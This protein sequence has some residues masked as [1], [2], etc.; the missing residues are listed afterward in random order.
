[1]HAP[2]APDGTTLASG[3]FDKSVCVAT[4][5]ALAITEL[6]LAQLRAYGLEVL[7]ALR[8]HAE[9]PEDV[10]AL[11]DYLKANAPLQP[12]SLDHIRVSSAG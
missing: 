4:S 7:E 8:T 1:M 6:G 9:G 11:E 2:T 10:E 3:S 5:S 12:P